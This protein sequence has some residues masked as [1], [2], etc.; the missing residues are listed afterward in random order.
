ML[1]GEKK[2]LELEKE[3]LRKEMDAIRAAAE[4][5]KAKHEREAVLL[6]KELARTLEAGA[7]LE[8]AMKRLHEELQEVGECAVYRKNGTATP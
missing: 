7:N 4:E 3:A 1:E 6:R 2:G 5:A 8:R